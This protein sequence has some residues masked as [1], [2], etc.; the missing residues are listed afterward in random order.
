MVLKM[1]GAVKLRVRDGSRPR[2]VAVAMSDAAVRPDFAQV[3]RI[4][5]RALR[6]RCPN[7]GGG[8]VWTSWL[9]MREAC[10]TCGLH[11]ERGEHGYIVGAYM[12]NIVFAELV[13]AIILISIA[14][15]T[16]P[17]PPWTFLQYGGGILMI[18]LPFLFYP[19][20]KTLFLA[21]DLTF[22]PVG[23]DRGDAVAPA[24]RADRAGG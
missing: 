8:G 14:V 24:D 18:V 9:K 16:W 21:F 2:Y 10:P 19:F 17:A 5:G 20:S 7:C 22:R 1:L 13:F 15:A 6:R 11:F 23:Y 4:T 12:F 3:L